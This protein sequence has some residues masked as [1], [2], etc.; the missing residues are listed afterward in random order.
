MW[1]PE[2][3]CSILVAAAVSHSVVSNSFVI[4]WTVARQAPLSMGFSWQEY[5]SG[6][7]FPPPGDFPDPGGFRTTWEACTLFYKVL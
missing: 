5:W 4:P 2:L 7:S 6:V 3:L 1:P